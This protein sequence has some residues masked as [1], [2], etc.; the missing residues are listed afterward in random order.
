VAR[1]HSRSEPLLASHRPLSEGQRSQC[2]SSEV[3]RRKWQFASSLEFEQQSSC[4]YN[5]KDTPI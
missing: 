5:M 3:E 1:A 2:S 4:F